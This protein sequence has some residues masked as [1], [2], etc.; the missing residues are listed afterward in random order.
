MQTTL[1]NVYVPSPGKHLT[2]SSPVIYSILMSSPI[3]LPYPPLIHL[4]SLLTPFF[5]VTLLLL[6]FHAYCNCT[7][8]SVLHAISFI[9][10]GFHSVFS[11]SLPVNSADLSH[12]S[13]FMDLEVRLC[14][15]LF[16]LPSNREQMQQ[17]Q[18]NGSKPLQGDHVLGLTPPVNYMLTP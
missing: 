5:N 17:R 8:F 9:N 18:A 12:T 15:L 14:R 4:P 13:Q 11:P 16:L 3:Y 10:T 1:S 6:L 7:C 2:L